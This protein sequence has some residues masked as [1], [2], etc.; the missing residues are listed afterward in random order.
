M[1]LLVA[2]LL[3]LLYVA[4]AGAETKAQCIDAHERAQS[5]RR[6]G[7]M[8]AA[9]ASLLVCLRAAC[10][11]VLQK[12]CGPWLE[13]LTAAE[14]SIVLSVRDEAGAEVSLAR[15]SIDGE[16]VGDALGGRAVDVDPG[17]HK[18]RVDLPGRL[19]PV[20]RTLTFR[21]GEQRRPVRIDFAGTPIARAADPPA[22]ASG[23]R[24]GAWML[25]SAGVAALGVGVVL[26]VV[27]NSAASDAHSVCAPC[28]QGSSAAAT[29]T[30]DVSAAKSERV[31]EGVSFAVS[32]V[33]L[34]A[35]TYLFVSPAASRNQTA[36]VGPTVS[37]DASV[38]GGSL[39]WRLSF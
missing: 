1:V 24:V 7:Q 13:Q 27:Q 9:R 8:R 4:P 22:S 25:G 2:S 10:P 11:A 33:A 19:T 12:E 23:R 26:A 15:V 17:E 21:E 37:V 39:G 35:A 20:E 38:R 16:L 29:A 30:S 34:A 28:G 14:P 36:A 3:V 18:L 31:W 5:L 32:G 6:A